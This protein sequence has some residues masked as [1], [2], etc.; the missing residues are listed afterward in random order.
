MGMDRTMTIVMIFTILVAL[1]AIYYVLYCIIEEKK[2]KNPNIVEEW[3]INAFKILFKLITSFPHI[4][5]ETIKYG[6]LLLFVYG[7]YYC[8]YKM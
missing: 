1:G 5:W 6:C 7:L 2:E 8:A 4:L 3:N